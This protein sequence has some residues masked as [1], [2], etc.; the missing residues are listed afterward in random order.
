MKGLADSSSNFATVKI[1]ARSARKCYGIE[2]R[3]P[4]DMEEHAVSLSRR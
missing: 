4:F 1:G 3:V 2:G